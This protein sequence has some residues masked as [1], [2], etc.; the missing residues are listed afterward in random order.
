MP[1][2]STTTTGPIPACAGEPTSRTPTGRSA[3]AYPRVCGG[4]WMAL[5]RSAAALGLSPRVRGNR[6][7]ATLARCCCG[8]IP[9]CA[10]EPMGHSVASTIRWAYPRVCGG[11]PRKRAGGGFDQ[12]LS[13]RVRG[14]PTPVPG[15]LP[16]PGP[17]PACAGEP[18]ASASPNAS[19]RAYPR[20]CGGTVS[21]RPRPRPSA[22]LSPRVRGNRAAHAVDGVGDGPIPACAGEPWWRRLGGRRSRA[23]PR[24]C[25][26]TVVRSAP[27]SHRSGLSPRVRGNRFRPALKPELAGPIPACAGEPVPTPASSGAATAYPRVCGGTSTSR[28]ANAD[29]QGLSPRVR[30][31]R[32]RHAAPQP[33]AGPIPA[34]AGEPVHTCGSRRLRRAY[35]RVCGGTYGVAAKLTPAQGLSPRVRGN[36]RHPGLLW[37][38]AG[39]IPAC[40]GEPSPRTSA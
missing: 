25:G 20:V 15:A 30:G 9:A 5:P 14:N 39:P 11:T 16:C 27:A 26:G 24:V 12:G 32:A 6:V 29:F 3:R 1:R 21:R 31:N 33:G 7:R 36:R 40:A 28:D 17:I 19:A 37:A 34:C 18:S 23:Y 35:P 10:G 22:G 38:G 2:Q 4:T 8:P 13:P